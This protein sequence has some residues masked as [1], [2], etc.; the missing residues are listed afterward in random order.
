[1]G[2][3]SPAPGS[4]WRAVREP[5]AGRKPGKPGVYDGGSR[6]PGSQ[7]REPMPSGSPGLTATSRGE[8]AGGGSPPDSLRPAQTPDS[9][10]GV[11]GSPVQIRPSRP[12]VS[13][14]GAASPNR[15]GGLKIFRPQVLVAFC[16]MWRSRNVADVTS[17]QRGSGQVALARSPRWGRWDAVFVRI[18]PDHPLPGGVF[19]G[20]SSHATCDVLIEAEAGGGLLGLAEAHAQVLTQPGASAQ[21]TDRGHD[22]GGDAATPGPARRRSSQPICGIRLRDTVARWHLQ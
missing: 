10:L 3:P 21:G 22:H 12:V 9:C 8:S 4:H 7:L 5:A 17:R 18:P 14:S 6:N 19:V 13:R 1:M 11:K 2:K 20:V 15:R 16:G